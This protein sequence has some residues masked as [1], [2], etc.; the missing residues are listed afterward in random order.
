MLSSA[1]QPAP[2][3]ADVADALAVMYTAT[4]SSESTR[5]QHLGVARET[6]APV[7][8]FA[9][10]A[11]ADTYKETDP[12]VKIRALACGRVDG[13]NISS[14]S[15]SAFS[16]ADKCCPTIGSMTDDVPASVIKFMAPPPVAEFSLLRGRSSDG[17]WRMW[18]SPRA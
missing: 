8:E 3:T 9:P 16:S 5:L 12:V 10:P 2:V 4:C 13:T 7:T 15:S 17:G 18:P 6:P 1:Q 11:P 14:D